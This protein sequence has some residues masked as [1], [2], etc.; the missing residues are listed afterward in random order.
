M[1][2][3]K[4]RMSR[5]VVD[6]A[7]RPLLVVFQLSSYSRRRTGLPVSVCTPHQ[8]NG[9]SHRGSASGPASLHYRYNF[10]R[11]FLAVAF[12]SGVLDVLK[13]IVERLLFQAQYGEL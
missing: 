11:A 5:C 13:W 1:I 10:D 8:F 6:S 12:V 9:A 3:I 7:S 4:C 2:L